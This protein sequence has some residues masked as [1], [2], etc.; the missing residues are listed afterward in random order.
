MAGNSTTLVILTGNNTFTQATTITNGGTLVLAGE[1]GNQA[2]RSTASVTVGAGATL[3]LQTSDQVRDFAQVSLSGGTIQRASGVNEVFGALTVSS[4]SF[5]DFGTGAAG[6]LSFGTYTPSS[7]LT[8][9]NFDFG[10]TLTFKSN[11]SGSINNCSFFAF[12]NGGDRQLFVGQRHGNLHHHGH[13]GAVDLCR[14]AGFAW[15]D[16][17]VVAAA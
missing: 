16:A 12:E 1:G 7:L 2:L 15:A 13:P 9:Q 6:T 8:I 14:G 3:L 5:L 10:S 17:L 4:A 11:L